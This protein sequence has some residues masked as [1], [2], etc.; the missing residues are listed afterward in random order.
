MGRWLDTQ[1]PINTPATRWQ[2]LRQTSDP[3]MKF[4]GGPWY[5]KIFDVLLSGQYAIAGLGRQALDMD[6]A[7]A[8]EGIKSRASWVDIVQEKFPYEASEDWKQNFLPELKRVAPGVVGDIMLDPLWLL[9]P[10][11]IA[12]MLGLPTIISKVSKI[13]P[14][15]WIGEK[16]AKVKPLVVTRAG[17]PED[18]VYLSQKTLRNI[19]AREERALNIGRPI[20]GLTEAE[21][22]RVAQLMK[23]GVS[24][25]DIEKPFRE[26]AEPAIKEFQ[27]LGKRAVQE[28]L[29]NETT[30]Y[31]NFGRYMPR[32]YK[33]KEAPEGTMRF[34]GDRKPIRINLDRFKKIKDIPDDI[35]AAL[36]EI[37]TAGY[38]TA[39]GL[40]QLGQAIERAKFFR[41]TAQ[42]FSKTK[43]FKDWLQ[44]PI[45][46]ALGELSGKYISP[47]IYDDIQQ[48][49]RVASKGEKAYRT[50]IGLWKYS[51]VIAN[52]AT[53]SRNM[54][55]NVILADLGGLSPLRVDIWG[56]ALLDL[57][58]KG[59]Y[60]KELKKYS[61]ILTE[62]FYA[63]E[64]GDLLTAFEKSG[65]TN[66]LMKGMNMLKWLMKKGG[67]LYQAEEQWSKMALYIA[68]RKQGWEPLKAA[69]HAE[70]WLFNYREVP[71]FIDVLRGSRVGGWA[72]A[73]L[74]GTYPFI[75][76]SYKV[77]PRLLEI[78]WK[79]PVK[80]TKWMKMYRGVEQFVDEETI[81]RQR[82][83]LPDYMREGMY[84]RLPFKDESGRDQYLD[85]NFIL[86]WGD[87]GEVTRTIEPNHPF[88]KPI[89][90]LI[91]NK[92]PL[93]WDIVKPG[94]TKSESRKAVTDFLY[95][96][97]MPSLSPEIPGVT[98]GGYGYE[99]IAAS[100]RGEMDYSDKQRSI[101]AALLA[102]VIGI[103]TIPFD[104]EE[105]KERKESENE[106]KI[107]EIQ[108]RVR[109]LYRLEKRNVINRAERLK[110]E[111]ESQ[112]KIKE[113]GGKHYTPSDRWL[114]ANKIQAAQP[115][116]RWMKL[117]LSP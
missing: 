60:F 4:M 38:P 24:V 20:S 105:A 69:K 79:D 87:I 59:K 110:R 11:K 101:K 106:R 45:T 39:K 55:S 91:L 19:A 2:A 72:G 112:K 94:M 47:A 57:K 25:S 114:E 65:G 75:T 49:I 86:P 78:A 98:K 77:A 51:K 12:K 28:G 6:D 21:Q 74:S 73:A 115:A 88:W 102:A 93:G 63:R 84:L 117:Q 26:A 27:R 90:S 100:V 8:I 30:F 81:E 107:R 83:L 113:L 67:N 76:F 9:P 7:G 37:K 56:E 53:H 43:P 18:Y 5:Q 116:G 10:V 17:Q 33:S 66:I 41:Q 89:Y 99:K 80:L 16:L 61:N 108:S 62:T 23:G 35:R 111:V 71:P 97:M 34:F 1:Q 36:G 52:P 96:A 29:L 13:K 58:R 15:A 31:D 22:K 70:K 64:I 42:K 50:G 46:K 82:E 104:L 44:L 95:K 3:G 14:L 54:M 92:H 103:K 40:A 32:L 68:K 48:W 85:L 109:N